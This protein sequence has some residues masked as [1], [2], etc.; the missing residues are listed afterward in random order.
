[1]YKENIKIHLTCPKHPKYRPYT[2]EGPIRGG[3]T[4]CREM[5][6]IYREAQRLKRIIDQW[7]TTVNERKEALNGKTRKTKKKEV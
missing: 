3:C 1:M 7:Q 4:L 6:E 2:G 5:V